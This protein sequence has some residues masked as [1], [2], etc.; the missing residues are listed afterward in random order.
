M[1]TNTREK[2]PTDDFDINPGDPL[3]WLVKIPY[4]TDAGTTVDVQ[5]VEEIE[6]VHEI[7]EQ[8]P[9]FYAVD[10]IEVSH[11]P[12]HLKAHPGLASMTLESAAR[13]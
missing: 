11:N 6:D 12:E 4:R 9:N 13:E 7:I 8:G 1:T 5:T 2:R 10:R 3:R